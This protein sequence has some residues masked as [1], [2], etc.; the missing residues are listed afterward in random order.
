[1]SMVP[2]DMSGMRVCEVTGLY[3]TVR[4]ASPSVLTSSTMAAH[5]SIE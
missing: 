3:V 2:F 5:R 4:V 1:M